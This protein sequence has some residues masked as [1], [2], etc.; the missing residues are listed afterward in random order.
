MMPHAEPVRHTS[1]MIA[2][3]APRHVPGTVVFHGVPGWA[4]AIPL[5]SDA[6]AMMREAEGITLVLEGDHPAVH[7]GASRF[8]QITLDLHSALEGVGLIAAAATELARHGI[9]CNV[10]AGLHHDH[11]FVPAG[12]VERAVEVLER[13]AAEEGQR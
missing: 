9:A 5:L 2:G 4:E 7:A 12:A 13:R 8:A 6:R 1:A 10:I 3:M 11:L